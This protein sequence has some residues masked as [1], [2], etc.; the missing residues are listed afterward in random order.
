MNNSDTNGFYL[1]QVR[2]MLGT[3]VRL[4]A[5]SSYCPI[6]LTTNWCR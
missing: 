5:A 3:W 4:L 2:Y 6:V 1:T